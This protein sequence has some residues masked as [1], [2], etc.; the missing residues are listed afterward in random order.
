MKKTILLLGVLGCT[1]SFC[2][3]QY[4]E[5]WRVDESTIMV[6]A[7]TIL[8]FDASGHPLSMEAFNDSLLFVEIQINMVYAKLTSHQT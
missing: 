7:D 4:V 6:R 3:A 8:H 1:T 2:H 5:T